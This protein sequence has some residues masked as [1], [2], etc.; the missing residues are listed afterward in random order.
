MLLK[1]APIYFFLQKN[2]ADRKSLSFSYL[3][4]DTFLQSSK[5]FI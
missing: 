2:L 5:E 4:D 1:M 3:H